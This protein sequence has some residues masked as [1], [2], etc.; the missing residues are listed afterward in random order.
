MAN[1]FLDLELLGKEASTKPPLTYDRLTTQVPEQLPDANLFKTLFFRDTT[2]GSMI[3]KP[4]ATA[5]DPSADA[6][7]DFL[8]FVPRRHLNQFDAYALVTNNEEAF[9]VMR[10][11]DQE[12][13]ENAYVAANP[14][15]SFFYS[16]GVQPL[17][18]VNLLPGSLIFKNVSRMSATAKTMLQAGAGGVV[19]GVAQEF[20]V[21]PNKVTRELNESFMNVI[22]SGIFSSA[23]GGV[24]SA[25]GPKVS[26][27]TA[28]V[29]DRARR[30][31]LNVIVDN[32]KKLNKDGTLGENDLIN[33]PE[34]AKKG[35]FTSLMNR[36]FTNR[37]GFDAPKRVANELYDHGY[38]TVKNES[39]SPNVDAESY[40]KFDL[41]KQAAVAIEYQDIFFEQA[42]VKKGLMAETR[43]NRAA[44]NDPTG[45]ILNFER[46]D[47]EVAQTIFTGEPH[48][49]AAVNQAAKLLNDKVFI[50]Y[51]DAAINLGLLP[52]DVSPKNA[53]AYFSVHW[54]AQKIKEDPAGFMAMT[55]GWFEKVNE[56]VKGVRETPE[57]KGLSAEVDAAKV[58]VKV[59]KEQG[60][61]AQVKTLNE[62]I[63]SLREKQS[64]LAKELA[65]RSLAKDEIEGIFHTTGKRKGQLRSPLSSNVLEAQAKQTMD[66]IVGNDN[67]RLKSHILNQLNGKKSPLLDRSFLIPQRIAFEW[68]NKSASNVANAYVRAMSPVITMTDFAKQLGFKSI[69]EWHDSRIKDLKAEFDAK[70]K[71]VKGKAASNLDKALKTES[72]NITDSF[73]LLLGIYG[74]GPNVHDTSAA[75]YYKAFLDWNYI[76]LLGFMTLSS[77]PDMGMHVLTHGP[78]ATVYHGLVPM[79]KESIGLM[80]GM[81]KDD[82][83]AIGYC[84]EAEMGFRL[85]SMSGHEGL[86][87]EPSLFGRTFDRM[88]DTFGNIAFMNQWNDIQQNIAGRLS[89]NRTLKAIDKFMTTGEL[90]KKESLRLAR[91]GLSRAELKVIHELWVAAG[92]PEESG[93][94]VADWT[95]WD[96]KNKEQAG[97]LKSFQ[98]SVMKEIDANVIIPGL[99]DKPLIAQSNLG[100]LLL[101]F[102]NFQFAATNKILF[103][104]IQ[105]RHDQN[106]YFGMATMLGLGAL[107][108]VV[109]Q[110]IRGNDDIDL[111]FARLS[112]EAIDK[113]GLLGIVGETYNLA[114]KAG[115]GFG[116]QSSRYQSRGLWGALLGPSTGAIEDLLS[117]VNSIR[118][119]DGEHPLTTKDLEKIMRLAPYQNLFYT[120][121][122]SRKI[123]KTQGNKLGFEEVPE[124]KLKDIF[125]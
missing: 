123:A 73:S 21:N 119:A 57:Y 103:S 85:K 101:Q 49:N 52:K 10:A 66:R 120:Y 38:G 58:A 69:K 75:K 29:R 47:S 35:M 25:F 115:L 14:W 31:I 2:I 124:S 56:V 42:G 121:A 63:K 20:I 68:Q 53:F 71:T 5:F 40:V 93:T 125:K 97:A 54:N 60:H 32:T 112:Q 113:S 8:Q 122:L 92:R 105:R 88:V 12:N 51:R 117:V 55:L 67:G 23:V 72:Q 37:E 80:K 84:C 11:L 43:A 30:E 74:D 81:T 41:R 86:S 91:L 9:E 90:S 111:S 24:S 102:K 33:M 109:T 95:N 45:N 83:K 104:G 77:I 106:V 107:S 79:L 4:Q 110:K 89:I 48:A 64:K 1:E 61:T 82:L 15:K 76:R 36:M 94:F 65:S 39:G 13:F 78:F 3:N 118:K 59:A 18:P 28:G 34:W 114:Q 96:I 100:K 46:F 116:T 98:I 99:G 22:S 87:T 62:Q 6:Q 108:Y 70:Q 7:D 26:R 16:F 27:Y 17:D 19:S 44:Q 50:P